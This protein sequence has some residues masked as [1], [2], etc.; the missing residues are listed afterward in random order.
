MAW[1]SHGRDNNDLV[2]SLVRNHLL[3]SPEIIKA[4]K[5]IDRYHFILPSAISSR[6]AAYQDCPQPI[7]Y[8]ATISAPHMHAMCL[9]LV[10]NR[11]VEGASVLDIG[12]GSGY[13]TAVMAVM[14]GK[15][16]KVVGLE[17]MKELVEFSNKNIEHYPELT[18]GDRV[19]F[20][21]GDG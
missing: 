13:L 8:G 10:K 15:T 18:S 14:V 4:M 21:H 3:K 7:G 19:K 1:F 5:A 16:G 9:E 20:I 11:L 6:S 17:H 2:D 12:S